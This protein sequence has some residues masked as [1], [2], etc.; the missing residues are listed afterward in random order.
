MSAFSLMDLFH[1]AA[2]PQ[3]SSLLSAVEECPSLLWRN[4]DSTVCVSHVLFTHSSITEHWGCFY[5]STVVKN[6][7]VD[8]GVQIPLGFSDFVPSDAYPKWDCWIIQQFCVQ[9]C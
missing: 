1:L 7:P 9:F 6:D 3:C 8:M 2:R 5:V 4:S